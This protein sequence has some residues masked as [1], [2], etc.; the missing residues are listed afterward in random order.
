MT[1][2]CEKCKRVGGRHDKTQYLYCSDSSCSCHMLIEELE[3]QEQNRSDWLET[4]DKNW[5]YWLTSASPKEQLKAFIEKELE[6]TRSKITE[7]L[8]IRDAKV[9][10]TGFEAGKTDMAREVLGVIGEKSAVWMNVKSGA[11]KNEAAAVIDVLSRLQAA[12]T[13]LLEK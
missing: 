7:E 4:L 5:Q 11:L 3:A 12:I 9:R 1:N 6:R 2:C 10:Q 13:G 8:V